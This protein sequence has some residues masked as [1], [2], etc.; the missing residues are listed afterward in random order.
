MGTLRDLTKKKF[1]RLTVISRSPR[2]TKDN[3]VRWNC[4]CDCGKTTT[5]V[6]NHLVSKQ[7]VSCG[8]FNRESIIKRSTTH[9]MSKCPE[10][11]IRASLVQTCI[12]PKNKNYSKRGGKGITICDRW[13]SSFENFYQDMGPRPGPK[14]T[15]RR[16]DINGNY[17]ANNCYWGSF[18][19]GEAPVQGVV[20]RN[21]AISERTSE[22]TTYFGKPKNNSTD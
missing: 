16:H 19:K 3:R 8:C 15:L 4:I 12:N 18:I 5:V 20:N 7:I 13:L 11:W 2:N 22:W 1:S 17:D 21:I 6:S 9:G 10:Y 14:Y